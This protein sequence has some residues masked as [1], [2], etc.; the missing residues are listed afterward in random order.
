MV[1][2][3]SREISAAEARDV[4]QS[5]VNTGVFPRR[6]WCRVRPA[7]ILGV[8][9]SSYSAAR[10]NV[11]NQAEMVDAGACSSGGTKHRLP[12]GGR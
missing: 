12:C 8:A 5:R 10:R 3:T 4:L 6:Y 11:E 7:V 2:I 9:R 1:A